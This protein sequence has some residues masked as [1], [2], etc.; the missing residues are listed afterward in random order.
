M[1]YSQISRLF[2]DKSNFGAARHR[3]SRCGSAEGCGG[4]NG[5]H[6]E[7]TDFI[8]N[9]MFSFLLVV[10][11]GDMADTAGQLKAGAAGSE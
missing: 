1:S 6:T 11:H 9:H 4:E 8:F 3:P 7:Y 2:E 5:T 10:S